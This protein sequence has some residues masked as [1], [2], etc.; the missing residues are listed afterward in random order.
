MAEKTQFSAETVKR[1]LDSLTEVENFN[2]KNN[3]IGKAYRTRA[4]SIPSSVYENGLLSTLSFLYAKA[5]KEI[6]EKILQGDPSKLADDSHEKVAY[7]L[8]LKHLLKHLCNSDD[9]KKY[10]ENPREFMKFLAEN[11]HELMVVQSLLKPF[12]I[13]LKHLA[14]AVLEAE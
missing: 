13:E 12:L 2:Q 7:A 9:R 3:K 5:T 1:A 10:V 8:Y 4:R 11:P 14:E 6:Y